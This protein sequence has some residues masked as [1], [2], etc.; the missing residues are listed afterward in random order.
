MSTLYNADYYI[1]TQRQIKLLHTQNFERLDL[2]NLMA[3]VLNLATEERKELKR[4]V[5]KLMHYFLKSKLYPERVSG[6]WLG[7]LC[8]HRH[9]IAKLVDEMPSLEPLLD[10]YIAEAYAD[11]TD[12]LTT[13]AR[14]PRSSFP[15]TLAY[16]KEQLLEQDFMPWTITSTSPMTPTP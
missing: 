8:G 1:W 10:G 7:K 12:R 14:L 11:I 4:H 16:T 9:W 6:R 2:E 5:R 3:E 13:K 15:E